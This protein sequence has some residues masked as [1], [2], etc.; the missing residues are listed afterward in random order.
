[1]AIAFDAGSTSAA[2]D[3]VTNF[4]WSHTCTGADRCLVVTVAAELVMPTTVT[5]NGV[6]MTAVTAGTTLNDMNVRHYVL[7]APATGANTVSVN[8]GATS[9]EAFGIG[10]S[11]TGVDQ[12]TPVDASGAGSTGSA[13]TGMGDSIT[14]VADNSMVVGGICRGH[15]NAMTLTT[16]TAEAGEVNGGG[17]SGAAA[18]I[19]KATAGA[20]TVDWSGSGG[21]RDWAT[22]SFSLAEV[23]AGATAALTT[24]AGTSAVGTAKGNISV[25]LTGVLATAAV[26]TL[27]AIK[28]LALA[29]VLAT[30]AVGSV[31]F[32]ESG[33]VGLT[34]NAGTS[35]VG[36]VSQS[37]TVALT[38]V[39]G[40][41]AVGTVTPSISTSAVL[42]GVSSTSA[43][44]SV[45]PSNSVP[46]TG[47]LGTSAVGTV[48]PSVDV[49]TALTGVEAST[50]GGSPTVMDSYAIT[51]NDT[52]VSLHASGFTGMGQ[53][54]TGDG[55]DIDEADFELSKTA[56]PTGNATAKVY[57][58]TGTFGT[59]AKPTGSALATSDTLDVSTLTGTPTTKTF[60]FSTPFTTTNGTKY[61][62]TIEYS[63]G[64]PSNYIKAGYDASSPSHAG[65]Y[66][67]L[68][69]S[70]L[71]I[72]ARDAGFEV[73]STGGGGGGVGTVSPGT[74]VALTG[75]LGTSAVG[76][77]TA[78]GDVIVPLT[79]V[80]GTSAVGSVSF[81][82]S[83]SV[84]LTGVAGTSAVG[85]VSQD[86]SIPLTGVL[87]TS[88]VDNVTPSASVQITGVQG[89][90]AVG[91]VTATAG[92][93][94]ALTGVVGTSNVGTVSESHSGSTAISGVQ[95]SAS[96]GNVSF[97][98]SGSVGLTGVASTGSVGT[99]TAIAG[100]GATLTG[101]SSTASVGTVVASSPAVDSVTTSGGFQARPTQEVIDKWLAQELDPNAKLDPVIREKVKAKVLLP[102][103][104]A[105]GADY[106]D[107][108]AQREAVERLGVPLMPSEI[109]RVE[110]EKMALSDILPDYNVDEDD[111]E[112]IL[113]L[114]M[115]RM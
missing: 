35:A 105:E 49:T 86:A 71:G 68:V 21:V 69:G 107:L 28:S 100:A 36:S 6:S 38:G 5:Y 82:E 72:S 87:G 78:G 57:A 63:G 23:S 98:E 41:S 80:S 27:T 88:A 109:K 52:T 46:L 76:T 31:G 25:G 96:V 58:I 19:L 61:C 85:S 37:R 111:E 50:G 13:T 12:T 104:G 112:A 79:G 83:G 65:N 62:I 106:A 97:T 9:G 66:S 33:N 2:E 59:N 8:F 113:L 16:G 89:T 53:A 20:Q 115:M 32:T 51:N 54:F 44:D 24:V 15:K 84:G 42:T 90:S 64:N 40:T 10:S 99:V 43:V 81:T 70:W 55:N 92:A 91:T 74:S 110:V 7:A 29:G 3:G 30:S 75:V 4:T 22:E 93:T 34:G 103:I 45:S 108:E 102:K 60:T 18:Y 11:F 67:D 47:I 73:R 94:V 1:M 77:V 95:V 56:S 17:V 26:G 101:V 14:T 48:S 39:A 114:T